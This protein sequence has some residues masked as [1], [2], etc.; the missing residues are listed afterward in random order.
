MNEPLVDMD[1]LTGSRRS[2]NVPMV[3]PAPTIV[4]LFGHKIEERVF[5]DWNTELGI[6]K[7]VWCFEPISSTVKEFKTGE[8]VAVEVKV[9][10]S[11]L[12]HIDYKDGELEQ[13]REKVRAKFVEH[14]K[15]GANA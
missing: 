3:L 2:L 8:G 11:M 1:G 5:D 12:V 13:A 9:V 14:Y 15:L 6:K 4:E 7:L 10:P